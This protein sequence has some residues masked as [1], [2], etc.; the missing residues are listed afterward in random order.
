MTETPFSLRSGK[1]LNA[2]APL[3]QFFGQSRW[4]KRF[5]DPGNCDFTI[6]NPHEMPS[7]GYVDALSRSV[8][9]KDRYWFAYKLNEEDARNTVAA[10]LLKWRN[11]PF[12][13]RDIFLTNGA[14]GALAVVLHTILDPGDEVIYLSP[15][16][17]LYEA[18]IL[19]TGAAPVRV[20]TLPDSFD[21]DVQAIQAALTVKSR[22]VIINSP[23]NPSGRIYSAEQMRLLGEILAEAS[24]KNG[25]TVYLISDE[26]YARIV[27]DGRAYPSPTA[28]YDNS[29]LVYTYGK[30]LLTPGQRIGYIALPPAL[31]DRPQLREAILSQ[32]M[33]NSWAFPNALMQ[34]ALADLEQIPFDIEALQRKR[35]HVVKALREIGY[36]CNVPEGT[37]YCMVR[38]PIPD[39][40]VFVEMLAQRD[41]YC[42]PGSLQGA[43]GYFRLSLTATDDM[44]KRALPIFAKVLQQ[45][46]TYGE[47]RIR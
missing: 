47:R 6:G 27:F 34:H 15:S 21:L 18:M 2:V 28:C 7:P 20:K 19:N 12:D 43:D 39:D 10:S 24:R 16:W 22:A 46:E 38:S 42:I 14:T 23:N 4:S 26:A 35:D 29:F 30:T 37:F 45:A 1:T 17:F 8:T 32:Q 13:P 40:R 36:R 41:V 33:L 31:Q 3:L 11:V 5:G 25:R 44:I 9:P